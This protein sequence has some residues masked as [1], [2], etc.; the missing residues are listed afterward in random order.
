MI[1]PASSW[2][3]TAVQM[4]ED[5]A[6]NVNERHGLQGSVRAAGVLPMAPAS[7][8]ALLA[9]DQTVQTW[10]GKQSGGPGPSP[11]APP[12]STPNMK[13]SSGSARN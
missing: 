3:C 8:T 2:L 13:A 11:W 9:E 6:S 5:D 1:R 10:P 7:L 4:K 12:A